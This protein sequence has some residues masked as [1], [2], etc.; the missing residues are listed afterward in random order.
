MTA[1]RAK[2]AIG[3]VLG[4]AGGAIAFWVP[5]R[6]D[7]SHAV[8]VSPESLEL[9][10]EPVEGES[11][12][13]PLQLTNHG[14]REITLQQVHSGC[15]CTSIMTRGGRPFTEPMPIPPGK[16]I[17]WQATI[18]TSGRSGEQRFQVGFVLQDN[19]KQFERHATIQV[20]VRG[21]WRADPYELVL[22]ELV[23]GAPFEAELELY[24]GSPDPG[25]PLKEA[26]ST[27]PE[28]LSVRVEQSANR[29][30]KLAYPP[31]FQKRHR[32][33]VL[34]KAPSESGR[35]FHAVIAVRSTAPDVPEFRIPVRG[36]TRDEEYRLHPPALDIQAVRE[37]ATYRRVVDCEL[38]SADSPLPD[39]VISKPDCFDVRISRESETL[40]RIEVMCDTLPEA[41]GDVP[42]SFEIVLGTD[43]KKLVAI[44]VHIAH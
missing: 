1:F 21:G 3:M 7:S 32:L 26:V 37:G 19:G 41:S 38:R 29:P 14:L 23:S 43:G 2:L 39:A 12:T 11:I 6:L 20:S 22:P 44:P 40:A 42:E 31:P 25:L 33:I 8:E 35:L 10:H 24:D 30:G 34:G 13:I 16:S 9:V 27:R 36:R 4:L 5:A 17:P 28:F 18:D 15:S